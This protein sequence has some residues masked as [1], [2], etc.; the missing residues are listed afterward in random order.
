MITKTIIKM[1][2]SPKSKGKKVV[3]DKTAEKITPEMKNTDHLATISLLFEAVHGKSAEEKVFDLPDS[4]SILNIIL[5]AVKNLY[6]EVKKMKEEREGVKERKE[7]DPLNEAEG[8]EDGGGRDRGLIYDFVF[9]RMSWMRL[10]SVPSRVTS[11]LPAPTR[12]DTPVSS[13]T[14]PHSRGRTPNRI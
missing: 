6:E 5:P 12:G 9:K 3:K 2:I 11:S 8:E 1:P 4:H 13:K 7:V 10:D 14:T